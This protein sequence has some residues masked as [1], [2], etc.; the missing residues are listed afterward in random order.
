MR[1]SVV[2]PDPLSPR[3]V[4]NSPSAISRET[5]RNTAFRPKVLATFRMLSNVGLGASALLAEAGLTMLF[6]EA[7]RCRP[8]AQTTLLCGFHIIPDFGVLRAPWHVLPEIQ[9]L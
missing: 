1:R 9:A 2:L 6:R 3:M 8:R 4:R 7:I 5:S